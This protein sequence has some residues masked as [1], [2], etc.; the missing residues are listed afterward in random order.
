MLLDLRTAGGAHVDKVTYVKSKEDLKETHVE[1][2]LQRL[3]FEDEKVKTSKDKDAKDATSMSTTALPP[4]R[5]KH[6][7]TSKGMVYVPGCAH[8]NDG[9]DGEGSTETGED[10]DSTTAKKLELEKDFSIA[11]KHWK[12]KIAS[13]EW[14]VGSLLLYSI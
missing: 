6:P 13:V 12:A 5:L 9:S 8:D 14:S 4:S 3:K 11:W 2:G 10:V 7:S 1:Y